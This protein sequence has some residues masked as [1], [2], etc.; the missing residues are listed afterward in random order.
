MKNQAL[1]CTKIEGSR[2]RPRPVSLL[3]FGVILV[4]FCMVSFS[5]G[6]S[7]RAETR[8]IAAP[9]SI[10]S[11]ASRPEA[12]GGNGCPFYHRR[13][14]R[15]RPRELPDLPGNERG[16]FTGA[17]VLTLNFAGQTTVT[18]IKST[19][20]DFVIAPGG[21]C[22]KGI[23]YTRGESCSLH[24]AVYAART[25]ASAGLSEDQALGRGSARN[26]W[27][28]RK[29]LCRGCELHAFA[30]QHRSCDGVVAAPG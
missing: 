16:E 12:I 9:Q 2:Q 14:V 23:S 26:R 15:T 21:T 11:L 28:G 29:R 25:G 27:S 1:Q 24:R 7:I 20:K 18:G 13:E 5:V 6:Q 19:N 10:I 8:S 22:L 4:S 17:E 30:D 3:V